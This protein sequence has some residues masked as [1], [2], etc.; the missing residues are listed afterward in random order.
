MSNPSAPPPYE[1]RNPLYPGPPPPG[2]YGQPSVLPGG[3]PAYPG[4]PQPGYGHPAGYPQPMPPINPMPMNYGPG[5]GYDGEERAVSDSFGPGEWDDRKVRHTFIR[6]V[7]SIISVQLLITVAIIAIF[8][9]VFGPELLPHLFVPSAVFVVTYLILAC[10]QGPSMY[11]TKAVIIAMIITAV[12]SISVTIFCFQ[13]KV[14]FTSC[15]G[16][17]CVLGIVLLVTGIVTSIVLY[18]QYVYWL[19]ML[20]AALGAICFTLFLAYDTQL[21]LGNRKHT[22]SPEDYI[23]GALQIYTDIIYIFTFVLQLMGDRN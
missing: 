21:V 11:Q 2:G 6:K 5:H 18:F 23:T 3:Y 22:I 12:V 19:H 20:Y 7:Y 9:F 10:C 16:L 13:T 17:F 1:D 14:D 15:T 4:Y 8:T